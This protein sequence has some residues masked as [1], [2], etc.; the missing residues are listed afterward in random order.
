MIPQSLFDQACERAPVIGGG[1]LR[2]IS[3]IAGQPESDM[4]IPRCPHG[5][6]SVLFRERSE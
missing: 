1:T 4:G 6:A 3:E 2:D 5:A